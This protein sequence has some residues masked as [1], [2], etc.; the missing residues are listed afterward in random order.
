MEKLNS[1]VTFWSINLF[2][3]EKDKE[4]KKLKGENFGDKRCKNCNW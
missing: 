4:R 3:R 2:S 1:M